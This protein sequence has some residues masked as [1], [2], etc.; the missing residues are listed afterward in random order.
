MIDFE[1]EHGSAQ[2]YVKF[3]CPLY[4]KKLYAFFKP[5]LDILPEQ[6]Y[7]LLPGEDY[8]RYLREDGR[9]DLL[10]VLQNYQQYL[11]RRSAKSFAFARQRADGTRLEAACHY[12]LDCYL[13]SMAQM[14]QGRTEVE[15]PT[16]NGKV[17]IFLHFGSTRYVIEIKN[18]INESQLAEAK[19]QAARYARSEGLTESYLVVFRETEEASIPEPSVPGPFVE[20]CEGVTLYGIFI[21]IG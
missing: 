18:Y 5:T 15:F 13:A 7:Y 19:L 10:A 6:K 12:S 14:F 9:F 4:Q 16:G 21:R 11:D 1:E 20:E 17:D 3:T 8:R 2:K